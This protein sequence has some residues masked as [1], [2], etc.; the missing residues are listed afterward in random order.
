[1]KI[2]F[3]FLLI[4]LFWAITIDAQQVL[5][6]DLTYNPGYKNQND[7][8]ID[9]R[10]LY[11]FTI[12]HGYTTVVFAYKKQEVTGFHYDG[13]NYYR[14]SVNPYGIDLP[15][16]LMGD[17]NGVFSINA[18]LS[19]YGEIKGSMI[20]NKYTD[21][22]YA[23]DIPLA[24]MEDY[25][26]LSDDFPLLKGRKELLSGLDLININ[27]ESCTCDNYSK[28]YQYISKRVK[29]EKRYAEAIQ[30]AEN[31]ERK[32]GQYLWEALEN[33]KKAGRYNNNLFV[34]QAIRR[35]ENRIE[36]LKLKKEAEEAE[37][38]QA[39]A[40]NKQDQDD[41]W[42]T[43]E[44]T[45]SQNTSDDDFWN[46][47]DEIPSPSKPNNSSNDSN[48]WDGKKNQNS[49]SFWSRGEDS[50]EESKDYKIGNIDG[51]TGVIDNNGKTLIPFRNW[52]IKKY[53]DG[54][55][56]V[57]ILIS[58]E[59]LDTAPNYDDFYCRKFYDLYLYEVGWVDK[60]GNWVTPKEKKFEFKQQFQIYLDRSNYSGW[61][62]SEE[63]ARRK[64]EKERLTREC[65]EERSTFFRKKYKELADKGYTEL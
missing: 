42:N 55:A 39:N 50:D 65:E 40:N 34:Q 54:I 43:G 47:E 48:F 56:K 8:I 21:D 46:G 44:D 62:D 15:P 58:S 9:I 45:K 5:F 16:E 26:I 38:N 7:C 4:T 2:K 23:F 24:L 52:S 30:K 41:F 31:A 19:G 11:G 22:G 10:L 29:K 61:Q 37:K 28:L 35:V 27:V 1:M 13:E 57:S 51:L 6:K 14:G 33:Y 20:S 59:T 32:G 60:N 12:S 49:P 64:R 17:N 3:F 63:E 53:A 36:E 18:T 25:T